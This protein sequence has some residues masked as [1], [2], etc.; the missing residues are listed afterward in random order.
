MFGTPILSASGASRTTEILRTCASGS[1]DPDERSVGR[2]NVVCLIAE[3]GWLL[4]LASKRLGRLPEGTL[5]RAM[6]QPNPLL[7][8]SAAG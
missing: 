8:P 3:D 2:G 6:P 5:S 4:G 1:H 7:A